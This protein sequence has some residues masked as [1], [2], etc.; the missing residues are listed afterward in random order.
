MIIVTNNNFHVL[1]FI[2]IWVRDLRDDIFDILS[3][4]FGIRIPTNRYSLVMIAEQPADSE[5]AVW[6]Q[7]DSASRKMMLYRDWRL[8]PEYLETLQRAAQN[9]IRSQGDLV[10]EWRFFPDWKQTMESA[11]HHSGTARMSE[12][13]ESGVCDQNARVHGVENVYVADGSLVP[14]SGI[15]NTGLT[16]AALALRLS[17]H[18]RN[19]E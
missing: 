8:P 13:A 5:R 7:K 2:R 18:L 4:R 16:I 11:A 19:P 17:S 15:A 9:F 10:S 1:Q 6:G 12:T 14:A 3:F